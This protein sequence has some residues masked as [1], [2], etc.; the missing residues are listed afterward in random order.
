MSRELPANP[1]LEFLK[2]QAK[3]ALDQSRRDGKTM[4]LADAQHAIAREY[5]FATWPKLRAHVAALEKSLAPAEQLVAAVCA[6]ASARVERVLARQPDLNVD[7]TRPEYATTN[8][9]LGTALMGAV[10]RSDRKT[11]DA[12]LRGGADIHRRMEHGMGVLDEC[13][14]ALVPFLIERGAVLDAHSAARF[15]DLESLQRFVD[16]DRGV[17]RVQGASG[18]TPL[19]FAST[20]EIARFL[21]EHGAEIDALDSMYESTPAQHM[22]RVV[23][24]RHYRRDRQP[25]A[26]FLV[27]QGARTD[28]LMACALGDLA[29]VQRHVEADPSSLRVR[30]A[31]RS[32]YF[33]SLGRDRTPHQVARDFG[34]E[35]VFQFLMQHSPAEVLLSQA[36]ELGD[37]EVFRKYLAT[38]PDPVAAAG[39]RRLPDA[40]QNNNTNAARL[41]LGA[42]W[43]V[44]ARGEHE[45]TALQWASWH[46]NVELVREILRYRPQLELDCAHG[47]TAMGAALH[48]SMNGWHRATGDY[49]GTVEALLDAGA[50]APKFTAELEA[51]DAVREILERRVT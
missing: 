29:L 17:V 40:A 47:I 50:K 21:L 18:Q 13:A 51:S 49:V 44:D 5:G 12:L 30:V 36:L 6:S 46:G 23:Q 35:D 22:L 28:I 42:G 26:R 4:K 8:Y 3:A 37:E 34:H 14:P 16:T 25:I 48:G 43:P 1:N 15:G 41:M 38:H 19:H 32:I 7:E 9:A 11:I 27:R 2:K 31:E 10:Q 39:E 24:G 33:Q 45:M 20:V